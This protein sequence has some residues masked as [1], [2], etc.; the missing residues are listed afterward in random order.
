MFAYILQDVPPLEDC[1]EALEKKFGQLSTTEK[2]EKNIKPDVVKEKVK[3]PVK[4]KKESAFGGF[5]KGFLTGGSKP[6][7]KKPD[8]GIPFITKKDAPSQLQKDLNH[9]LK[10]F[11]ENKQNGKLSS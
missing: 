1:T 11:V 9:T 4:P 10:D 8:E 7:V 2:Q 3:E 6:K 5:S